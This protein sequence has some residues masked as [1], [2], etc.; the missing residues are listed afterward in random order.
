[1]STQPQPPRHWLINAAYRAGLSI[2]DKF[3]VDVRKPIRDA[4]VLVTRGLGV[5][6]AELA[7]AV[8]A[9]FRL[10]IADVTTASAHM[11]RV[12]PENIARQYNVL[13]LRE[14]DRQLFVAT[15]NPT[16]ANAEQAL[17]FASG[18]SVIFE[19]APPEAIAMVIN[20]LYSGGDSFELLLDEVS[21][22]DNEIRVVEETSD[23]PATLHDTDAAPI[24]RLTN[25]IIRDGIAS[26]ASDIHIEPQGNTGVVRMRIDGV[27][28]PHMQIPMSALGRV[29]SRIKIISKLDIA[30][31]LRPQDGKARVEVDGKTYDLRISTVP[32]RESEKAVVRIL[33]P[34]T[35]TRI[36]DLQLAPNETQRIRQLLSFRDGI[37][38]VTGPTG[39]GK[40][41][42]LYSVLRELATGRVNIM[43]VEDPIEYELPGI[44]QVQVDPKRGVTFAT[45]LRSLLRQD[46]DVIFVGEIRDEETAEVAMQASLTGHLVLAT[47]HTND[48]TG[49]VARMSELGVE[50]PA[51]S[52][53]LRGVIAQRLLRRVCEHCALDL[54]DGPLSARETEQANQYGVR[55][56]VRAIGCK[57]C[58]ETGYFGRL[59]IVEI[60]L[61]SSRVQE[62][63]SS[64]APA[65][66]IRDV[67]L[68]EGMQ[69]L[70]ESGLVRV[71]N[72]E[73]TLEEVDRVVGQSAET[74]VESTDAAAAAHILVVDD[75]AVSRR[76]ASALLQRNSFQVSEAANGEE[77]LNKIS[78]SH[79][80]SLVVLDLNM[81]KV[82]GWTVLSRL[83]ADIRTAALPVVVLTGSGEIEDEVKLLERG[84]ND[85]IRKPLDAQRFI[86]R[87]NAVLRRTGVTS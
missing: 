34:S 71:M 7:Q 21:D 8:A 78:A 5:S 39:S 33:R 29:I 72:K 57:N 69:T 1:M 15:A 3:S 53:A 58:G 36:A 80:Y 42:T 63:I 10:K 43:T 66:R 26:R 48:A 60:L 74:G 56:T 27:M 55:P 82:D 14:N 19:V 52:Q 30:D 44:T 6:D 87:I 13:P 61:N 86:E 49:V 85:Y 17:A 81:P 54:Q 77:A 68:D 65:Q 9:Q 75:D 84:A 38:V 25:L 70:R 59:P 2:P 76:L 28:R 83:R 16:D 79:T 24:I 11:T 22:Q 67:A 47:L 50:A 51:L 37:I 40:T 46:P 12:V 20:S 45:A 18:R 41:T 23:S 31:R 32:A 64:S 35:A 4:W 73:T 62:L